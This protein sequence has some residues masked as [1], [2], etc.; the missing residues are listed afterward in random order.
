MVIRL[1]VVALGA[2]AVAGCGHAARRAQAPP[3]PSSTTARVATT[4]TTVPFATYRVRPGDTLTKIAMQYRVSPSSIVTLNHIANPDLLAEGRILRI[5]PAPPLALVVK[6]RAGTQGQAF[7]L[8][9]TGA[10]PGEGV[11][12]EVHS[13]KDTFTGPQ[14]VVSQDGSVTAAYQTAF[15]DAVGKYTVVARGKA[16]PIADAT[17]VLSAST[18]VT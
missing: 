8:V 3:P 9:L 5:P 6:P 7:Q 13:P 16:G 4:T 17:F 11:T 14:H 1:V 10:P 18:P 12:F 15:G 2:A